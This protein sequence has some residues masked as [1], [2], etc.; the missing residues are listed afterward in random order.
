MRL[1]VGRGIRESGVPRE[2]IFVTTRLYPNQFADAENAII[3]AVVQNEI[4]PYYQEND[5][6]PYIQSLGIVVQGWYPLGGRSHTAALP[7]DV[8][9]RETLLH[10]N[11][12]DCL[13]PRGAAFLARLR[14]RVPRGQVQPVPLLPGQ[15]D[16]PCLAYLQ[17]VA[18]VHGAHDGL[19]M[20]GVP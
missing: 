19:D 2:E 6:I 14:K 8:C 7:G 16:L 17:Q 10:A 1:R 15:F 9:P 20:R 12:M 3:P 4:H 13:T 18:F 5:V 11:R